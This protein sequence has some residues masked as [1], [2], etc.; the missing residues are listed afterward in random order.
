MWV[1]ISRARHRRA[2]T[3]WPSQI[4][5]WHEDLERDEKYKLAKTILCRT[6][7]KIVL[8]SRQQ[9]ILDQMRT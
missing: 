7:M 4:D 3:V 5:D 2:P 6:N 8:E 1:Q 9:K